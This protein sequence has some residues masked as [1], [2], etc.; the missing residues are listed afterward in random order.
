M[1]SYPRARP[2]NSDF[3]ES[4]PESAR[5]FVLYCT[6]TSEKKRAHAGDIAAPLTMSSY[7]VGSLR[8]I[9]YEHENREGEYLIN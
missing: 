4:A 6:G 9:E 8:S 7:V 3:D 1:P 2:S 5:G